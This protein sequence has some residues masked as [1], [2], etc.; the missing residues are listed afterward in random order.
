MKH[1]IKNYNSELLINPTEIQEFKTDDLCD[2]IMTNN[3]NAKAAKLH[4]K[5]RKNICAETS[6]Y[7]SRND[8]FFLK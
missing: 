8:E 6:L 4:D 3:N 5:N 1:Q 2:Y 7:S